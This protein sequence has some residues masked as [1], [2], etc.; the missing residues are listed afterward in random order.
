MK[1]YTHT[2]MPFKQYMYVLGLTVRKNIKQQYRNSFLGIAW[3][4]LNP[5]LNMLVMAFVFSTIFERGDM[6]MDY[7]CYLLA[8]NMLFSFLRTSTNS[9]LTCIVDNRD[10]MTK[11]RVPTTTFALAKTVTALSNFGFSMI[12]LLCVMLV[13]YL[14]GKAVVFG[15]SMLLGLLVIPAMF[16]FCLGMGYILSSLFVKFRDILHIYSV[17]LTL[18]MYA[19]PIFYSLS[20]I[21]DPTVVQILQIN[22]MTAMID[23][24]R[25]TFI[26]G[27]SADWIQLGISY[28]W[29]VGVFILGLIIFQA[30]KKN[31]VVNI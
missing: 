27:C 24:F 26:A 10:L 20:I 17:I 9:S 21:D 28:A 16:L 4:V 19:T 11:T 12:A 2:K 1:K 25:N 14:R 8:G 7:P 30:A 13:Q 23:F 6:I 29:G 5:L 22:P 31:F 3:T 18:W 15:F